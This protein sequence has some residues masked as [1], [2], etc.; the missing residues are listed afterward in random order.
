MI[1]YKLKTAN[2]VLYLFGVGLLV[3][4][5][6]AFGLMRI[7]ATERPVR[8]GKILIVGST[9]TESSAI[10]Q[11]LPLHPGEVLDYQTLRTAEKNLATL[12]ATLTVIDCCENAEVRDILV[13]K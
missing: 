6:V 7:R 1:L 11:K 9:K 4:G 12:K 10:L 5:V 8:V 3:L 13:S 2:A